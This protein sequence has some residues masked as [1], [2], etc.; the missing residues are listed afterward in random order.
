M[1]A[2]V[3]YQQH[4]HKY[5]SCAEH[6]WTGYFEWE[7]IVNG[8]N[9]FYEIYYVKEMNVFPWKQD[10]YCHWHHYLLMLDFTCI[11]II[12]FNMIRTLFVS[13]SIST[14]YGDSYSYWLQAK[15][16]FGSSESEWEMNIHHVILIYI[17]FCFYNVSYSL[18]LLHFSYWIFHVLTTV[19]LNV[20]F[21]LN[22]F[23]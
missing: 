6:E 19:L 12:F 3:Y 2:Q 7:E 21:M 13:I 22:C 20:F 8:S 1:W 4:A 10:S 18:T 14:V 23:K 17:L 9:S 5:F 16:L 11:C 15:C